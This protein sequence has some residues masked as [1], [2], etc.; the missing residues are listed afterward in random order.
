MYGYGNDGE[1]VRIPEAS[2]WEQ[3]QCL[4]SLARTQEPLRV[5]TCCES[6]PQLLRSESFKTF[7]RIFNTIGARDVQ[8]RQMYGWEP[9]TGEKMLQ[10][11]FTRDRA[12]ALWKHL[13][14]QGK[15][16]MLDALEKNIQEWMEKLDEVEAQ[17]QE[18]K[19]LRERLIGS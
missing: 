14:L 16:D 10:E 5:G 12:Y 7:L 3:P 13:Q 9:A 4:E 11:K 19:L 1:T 18:V 2:V 6:L 17:E 15:L 8:Q